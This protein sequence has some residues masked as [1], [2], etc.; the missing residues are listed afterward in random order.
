MELKIYQVDAFADQVFS[1]N[2]AA[3]VPLENWLP[4]EVLQNIAL[5][6]NLSETA[7]FVYEPEGLRIRWFTPASEVNLC[8]HATLGTAHILFNHLNFHANIIEFNS[9]SG[10]LKVKKSG[11]LLWLDFPAS[12]LTQ[13]EI[14]ENLKKAVDSSPKECWHG[15]DDF[16]LIFEDE[17]T[18]RSIN[19]D[20]TEISKS[21]CRGL[22]V[23]AKGEKVDFVSRFFAPKV[24]VNEDPVTGS[25]HTMLIP[26]W[27]EKLGKKEMTARQV[28]K[29]SGNLKCINYGERVKIGGKAVTY[30]EGKIWV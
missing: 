22:I 21:E 18:I 13:I 5:E 20:F 14:P 16:M 25:A 3:V 4:G 11:D 8:G 2:P 23:T 15:R 29:R 27:S 26:Y 28:S 9:R 6:N 7:F 17:Q 19:P 1:G 30:L 10:L 12:K 24:G